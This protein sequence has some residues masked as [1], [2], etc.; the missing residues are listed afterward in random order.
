LCLDHCLA[1]GDTRLA[2]GLQTLNLHLLIGLLYQLWYLLIRFAVAQG[3]V[4][5]VAKGRRNS[6]SAGWDAELGGVLV[7]VLHLS[8]RR[9]TGLTL[10]LQL[11]D[12]LGLLILSLRLHALVDAGLAL[13]LQ[14]GELRIAVA[15]G[16]VLLHVRASTFEVLADVLLQV[17]LH[18]VAHRLLLHR[19]AR[20][21]PRLALAA[22]F[23]DALALLDVLRFSDARHKPVPY[24]GLCLFRAA[25]NTLGNVER[26]A[27]ETYR[28]AI[29]IAHA[30]TGLLNA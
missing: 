30:A 21:D 16:G 13:S 19:L 27:V 23:G 28:V 3:T 18:G 14:R 24:L 5:W 25:N 4:G 6:R 22:E 26:T 1:L 17:E 15:E 2:L 9:H 12:L 20:I 7:F 11:L 8:F 10:C 29:T